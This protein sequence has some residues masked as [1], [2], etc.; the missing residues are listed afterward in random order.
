M[1]G[2]WCEHLKNYASAAE[3]TQGVFASVGLWSIED[4]VI[5]PPRPGAKYLYNGNDATGLRRIFGAPKAGAGYGMRFYI[6]H[7]PGS[8][9]TSAGGSG[10][11]WAFLSAGGLTQM[12]TFLGSDGGL[13]I[14]RGPWTVFGGGFTILYRTDPVITARSWQFMEF[15]HVPDPVSGSYEVR[16]DGVTVANITGNTDPIGT[17]ETS[18]V[19]IYK[20]NFNPMGV[21]DLFAW[22]T[23][24]EAPTDFV[25]NSAVSRRAPNADTAAADWT[26][27]TGST[28]YPLLIDQSDATYVESNAVAQK[29]AFGAAALDAS[30][31]GIVFQQV[32]FR[33]LK[34]DAGDCNVAASFV[35]GVSE[36][37]VVGRPLT[38][39]DTWRWS[40]FGLDPATSSPWTRSGA[41]ASKPALTRTV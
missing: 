36:T 4:S 40:C 41:N 28:G 9:A 35:S 2:L 18:Q 5:A 25:G 39:S 21:S 29:S 3:L 30:A 33:A 8:D 34:T 37:G 19:Q 27:S 17:A 31:T 14:C 1:A 7:L 32:A 11:S 23:S 15:R 20:A 16:V 6:D 22:D 26:K 13:I 24:G 12:V 10:P 38:L